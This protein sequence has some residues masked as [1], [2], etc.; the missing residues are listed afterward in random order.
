MQPQVAPEPVVIAD[1]CRTRALPDT[2]GIDR[3][4]AGRARSSALDGAACRFGSSREE[5]ALALADERDAR[6]YQA[7]YGVDPRSTRGLLDVLGINLG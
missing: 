1:P 7:K 2:G 4:P 5:L 3:L 6:A